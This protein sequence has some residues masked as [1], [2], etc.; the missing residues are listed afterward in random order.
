MPIV[1]IQMLE[2]RD[3]EKKRQLI[4]AVTDAI[5][6]TLSAAPESVRVVLQEVPKAHWGTGGK[7][8]K[9]LGR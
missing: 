5:C 2:G 8:M 9:E 4:A 6:E 3:E 1:Q 7:T